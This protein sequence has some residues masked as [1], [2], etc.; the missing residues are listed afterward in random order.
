MA[1]PKNWK[2][3]KQTENQEDIAFA[4]KNTN[5][6]Q[7]SGRG[8]ARK[9]SKSMPK[10]ARIIVADNYKGKEDWEIGKESW[11]DGPMARY[12]VLGHGTLPAWAVAGGRD[13][14]ESKIRFSSKQKAR[15]KA[16]RWMRNHPNP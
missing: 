1:S 2:R 10:Q 5:K 9:L 14:P 3:D 8:I 6:K 13:E 11:Q 4:W 12:S 16:V 15:K 7:P